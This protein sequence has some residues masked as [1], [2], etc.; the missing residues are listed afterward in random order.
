MSAIDFAIAIFFAFLGAV[1][2][3]TAVTMQLMKP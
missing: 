2:L 1:A 3:G